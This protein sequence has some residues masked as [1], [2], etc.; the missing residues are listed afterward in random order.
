[1]FIFTPYHHHH[2]H[3]HLHHE[4]LCAVRSLRPAPKICKMTVLNHTP[5]PLPRPTKSVVHMVGNGAETGEGDFFPR[6]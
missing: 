6:L 1:M 2:H 4:M 5:P 3:R